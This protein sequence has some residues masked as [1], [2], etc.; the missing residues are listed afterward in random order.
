MHGASL[1]PSPA[2]HLEILH[3]EGEGPPAPGLP[4]AALVCHP[5][6]AHGGTMHNKVVY[7]LAR[8][9][10]ERGVSVLRFNFRGVGASTGAWSG[11]PGERDDIRCA[12]DHLATLHPGSP[13][14]VAGFSFGAWNGIA[15]GCEDPRVTRFIGLGLPVGTYAPE[16]FAGRG[17]PLFLLHGEADTFGSPAQLDAFAAAWDGPCEVSVIGGA[18]HFFEPRLPL[19][20]AEVQAHL[21][22][23]PHRSRRSV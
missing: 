2:G 13:L 16:P 8:A 19:V 14:L 6:P 3:R 7:R 15:V 21:D 17:R 23:T 11:G 12:L 10:L 22:V 20:T 1:L 5:H 4:P 18:D 9:L